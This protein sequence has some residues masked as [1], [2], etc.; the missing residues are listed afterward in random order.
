MV[1]IIIFMVYL[2]RHEQLWY[3]QTRRKCP[4]EKAFWIEITKELKFSRTVFF[5]PQNL[6]LLGTQHIFAQIKWVL[7]GV[8]GL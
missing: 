3:A 7:F 4:S 8:T 1:G 6:E 2:E 5:S